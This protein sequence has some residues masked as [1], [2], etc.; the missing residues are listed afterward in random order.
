MNPTHISTARA[1]YVL[2][3]VFE[4][5]IIR[6]FVKREEDSSSYD[7]KK[8]VSVAFRN[9]MKREN[10]GASLNS[11]IMRKRTRDV[12][13]VKMCPAT[14]EH[15]EELASGLYDTMYSRMQKR[16]KTDT[17]VR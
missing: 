8:A 9:F 5:N 1:S 10:L 7:V 3:A 15:V 2:P 13:G 14:P 6:L 17:S 11:P 12:A 4:E 16:S